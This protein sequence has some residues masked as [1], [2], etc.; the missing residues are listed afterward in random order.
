MNRSRLLAVVFAVYLYAPGA[1]AVETKSPLA[2]AVEK[3]DSAAVR[4]LLEQRADVNSAQVDGMTALHWAVYHED[5]DIAQSLVAAGADVT[6]ENRY[7]VPPLSI[8]CT[9]SSGVSRS[10]SIDAGLAASVV[11]LEGVMG[12]CRRLEFLRLHS[13]PPRC[14]GRRP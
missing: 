10:I 7:G 13:F 8:A 1:S 6:A 12:L 4:A 14:R 3:H 2:D 5:F 11:S 9:I